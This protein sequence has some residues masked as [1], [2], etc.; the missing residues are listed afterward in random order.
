M[1]RVESDLI[2]R[3][4]HDYTLLDYAPL[5]CDCCDGPLTLAMDAVADL[6]QSAAGTSQ[7]TNKALIQTHQKLVDLN[8]NQ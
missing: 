1:D 2:C 6:K 7:L 5:L 8:K 3:N 4:D